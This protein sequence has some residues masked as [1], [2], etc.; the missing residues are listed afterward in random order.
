MEHLKTHSQAC[1]L[2][3]N[4]CEEKGNSNNY[5]FAGPTEKGPGAYPAGADRATP[6]ESGRQGE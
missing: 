4:G 5:E 1:G 3:Y 6:L 2:Y